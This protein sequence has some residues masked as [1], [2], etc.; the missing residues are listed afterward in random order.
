MTQMRFGE[1]REGPQAA[2][3]HCHP[4]H[5]T[6]FAITGAAPPNGYVAEY[7]YFIGPAA[8]AP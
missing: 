8:V 7:E 1:G 3:V 2:V 6:A 5:A 4:L